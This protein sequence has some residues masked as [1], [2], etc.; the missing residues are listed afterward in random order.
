MS[1]KSKLTSNIRI[2]II[3]YAIFIFGGILAI[4][5]IYMINLEG[6]A[7]AGFIL[8]SLGSVFIVL[9]Y[10][11]ARYGARVIGT[12]CPFCYGVGYTD[13]GKMGAKE[14]CP[15]CEGS[16]KMYSK[17]QQHL[18]EEQRRKEI[19]KSETSRRVELTEEERDEN[20]K[21]Q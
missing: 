20:S 16:G 10:I 2:Y 3:Q 4:A 21:N 14:L 12:N 17:S 9:S 6:L 1:S 8:L 19:T 15:V 11:Y 7:A 18:M 5:G 13:K